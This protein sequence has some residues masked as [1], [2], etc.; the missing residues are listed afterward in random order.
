MFIIVA[1]TFIL[2]YIL[3]YH[4]PIFDDKKSR[5]QKNN[6]GSLSIIVPARNEEHNLQYLLGSLAPYKDK[7]KEI[8]VVDDHSTDSTA[9]VAKNL[10]AK[11]I[12]LKSLP[13]GWFGKSF[14]CWSGAK[15]ASGEIFLFL[16]A[17]TMVEKNGLERLLRGFQGRGEMITI[18][19]YHKTEKFYESFSSFFHLVI[20]GSLGAFHPFSK[21]FPTKGAFGQAMLVSREDYFSWG[22]HESI[23]GQIMENMAFGF[24]AFELGGRVR[25][26]SGKG[27]ITM[28]MYPEGFFSLIQGWSKSFAS[29]AMNTNRMYLIIVSLWISG[30][31]TFLLNIHTFSLPLGLFVYLLFVFQLGR[32]LLR[33]GNFKWHT[34]LLFPI[35]LLFFIFV[36]GYSCFRTF[37]KKNITWKNRKIDM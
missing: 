16:D 33:V 10:G 20:M 27:A 8:I 13:K 19:P 5:L 15:S 36:F 23:Q 35:M 14:G 22:G 9:K 26:Y 3:F 30:I 29:G 12:S 31:M 7:L 28:R 34:S 18:Q 24:K 11:V 25:A 21:W 4:I 6:L 32:I 1:V 17:D 37:I 2:G